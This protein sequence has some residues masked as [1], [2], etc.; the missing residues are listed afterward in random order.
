MKPDAEQIVAHIEQLQTADWLPASQKWWPKYLFHFT[1]VRNAANILTRGKF[2]SRNAL[3]IN[4]ELR[5]DIADAAVLANTPAAIRDNVRLYFR[6]LTNM[7]YIN[8]GFKPGC[9]LPHCPVPIVFLLD[10]KSVLSMD[11]T[12]F[13]N[14]N[15]GAGGADIGSNFQFFNRIPFRSVYHD[16]PL[17]NHN[18]PQANSIKFHRHAEV[19]VP[20]EL[21]T[22]AI[23]SIWGR[24]QAE[25]QTLVDLIPPKVF[26]GIRNK[27]F[28]AQKYKLFF[29]KRFFLEEVQLTKTEARIIFNRICPTYGPCHGRIEIEDVAPNQQPTQIWEDT[30]YTFQREFILNLSNVPFNNHYRIKLLINGLLAYQNTFVDLP[31]F[32]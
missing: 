30:N 20:N 21:S 29:K 14:G 32:F 23:K 1:D 7:Q 6:P 27:I 4:G 13:S 31:D 26:A 9:T 10:A 11:D 22:T 18:P 5:C 8:E 3:L 25:Y 24:S 2:E 19:I 17:P 15:L 16:E 12:R 28:F